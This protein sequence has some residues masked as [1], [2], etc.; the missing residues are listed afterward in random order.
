MDFHEALEVFILGFSKFQ[1]LLINI[2]NIPD[3]VRE[4]VS[5]EFADS[6]L[7]PEDRLIRRC[8][9]IQNSV[10]QSRVLVD[11]DVQPTIISF[12]SGSVFN[13]KRQ[14]R[15]CGTDHKNLLDVD[16]YVFLGTGFDFGRDGLHIC[17]HVDDRLLRDAKQIN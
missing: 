1:M 11:F 10:V 16:F 14:L 5:E 8:P 15:F 13:L 12:R 9:E 2:C 17:F 3:L 4:D 6:S 7:D